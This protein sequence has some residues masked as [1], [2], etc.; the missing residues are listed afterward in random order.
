MAERLTELT[1]EDRARVDAVLD[2]HGRYIESVATRFAPSR[3]LVP[4]VM[5]QVSMKLCQSLH[6][7]GERSN[8]RTWLFTVTRNEAVNIYRKERRVELTRDH[9]AAHTVDDVVD[10]EQNLVDED[11]RQQQRRMFHRG[12]QEA[13]SP[14]QQEAISN[15]TSPRG[16]TVSRHRSTL[17]RARQRLRAWVA[18]QREPID[19]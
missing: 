10:V 18:N 19:D 8:I 5:Q 9:V 4:D 15:M 16:V 1:D 17:T 6:T 13:L 14:R 11:E 3:D 7:F 12:M 2:T